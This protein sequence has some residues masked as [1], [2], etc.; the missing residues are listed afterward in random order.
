MKNTDTATGIERIRQFLE[1]NK[2]E[3]GLEQEEPKMLLEGR[4]MRCVEIPWVIMRFEQIKSSNRV[5]D[6]GTSFFERKYFKLFFDRVVLWS[7]EFQS[8]DIVPFNPGRFCDYVA[9]E[10][11]N[12]KIKFQQADIRN[13][14]FTS[15]YF[16]LIFCISMIEHVGFDEVN[17]AQGD[18]AFVRLEQLPG[19]LPA[20]ELWTED[21]KAMKEMARVLKPGGKLLLTVPF[22]DERILAEKDSLGLY[23]LEL[24]YDQRRLNK[25]MNASGLEVA[26]EKRF[27]YDEDHGWEDGAGRVVCS[28]ER[29][30]ACLEIEKL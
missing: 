28:Q 24:Q 17:P 12:E 20:V 14:P 29:T 27:V 3:I 10:A 4:S 19:D 9:A 23:A 21:F 30:V 2:A 11:L 8:L 7:G 26:E 1:D 15:D 13:M 6:L 25:L 16:D 22:G 18:S 5:L